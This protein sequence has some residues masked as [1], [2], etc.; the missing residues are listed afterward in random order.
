MLVYSEKSGK[1]IEM[2]DVEDEG[3]DADARANKFNV[4]DN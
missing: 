4:W 3:T 2:V 1:W